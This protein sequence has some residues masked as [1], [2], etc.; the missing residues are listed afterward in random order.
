MGFGC[1][2][3]LLLIAMPG[4]LVAAFLDPG[5]AENGPVIALAVQ[6]LFFA[7]VFQLADG[8]QV[9]GAGMLRGLKD[10][11]RPMLYAALGY[12]GIG[13]PVGLALAFPGRLGGAGLWIGLAVGLAAVSLLLLGRWWRREELGLAPPPRATAR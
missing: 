12:W 6:F 11:R 1:M 10:T 7:A 3:A 4:I 5:S 2:T 9:V 13:T 8:A